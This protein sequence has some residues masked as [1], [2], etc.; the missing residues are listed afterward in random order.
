MLA[1][2]QYLL[3]T[4]PEI[5]IL[6]ISGSPLLHSFRIPQ[7]LDY[8]KLPCIAR[9]EEGEISTK[10]L[11]T[12]TEDT[13]KLRG[14]LIKTAAINFKPDVI[15]VDKKPYGVEGELKPTL[16]YLKK[17]LP[18]TKTVLLLRDILD[19]PENTIKEWQDN[20]TY[21]AIHWYYDQV[22]VVGTKEIFNMVKEYKVPACVA[23]KFKFCGYIKRE[24][25]ESSP[26][27]IRRQ[28]KIEP[29]DKLVLVT[30]G[31]GADGYQLIETYL[32][33]LGQ[34]YCANRFKTLVV[35]GPEMAEVKRQQIKQQSQQLPLVKFSEFS[36]DLNS[37][38]NAADV[39]VCMGGYNTI[40]EVLSLGKKAVVV[41]R[42]KPVQEQLIRAERMSQQGLFTAIHPD[43]LN[44]KL[45]I[46]AVIEQLDSSS[47][48]LS[49][50]FN[51]D[52]EG[53]CRI[54]YYLNSLVDEDFISPLENSSLLAEKVALPLLSAIV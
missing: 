25:G 49:N 9:D 27:T 43:C 36:N 32:Q 7:N 39:V 12:K 48:H 33:G 40:C 20:G 44:N 29:S 31:G 21:Q 11:G 24:A 30:A 13:I 19:A 52:L 38:I 2:C 3:K 35:T 28:L 42:N 53:L 5:S 47:N 4:S 23:K 16:A 17:H 37:Y 10:Y 51:V 45:L 22:Q 46:N 26:E 15:L 34:T 8:I 14:N 50:L 1:I 41:P 54:S 18:Q 6:L